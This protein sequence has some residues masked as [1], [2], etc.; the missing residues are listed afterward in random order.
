MHWL[1]KRLLEQA[2]KE[3]Q[4][5]TLLLTGASIFFLGIGLVFYSEHFFFSSLKQ[6]LT[7]LAGLAFATIGAI[8]AAT[9]YI[10]LS[11]LRIFKIINDDKDQS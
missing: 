11:V 1:K 9:G 4:N 2:G 3:R 7:A 6:E 8:L 10:S 5:L